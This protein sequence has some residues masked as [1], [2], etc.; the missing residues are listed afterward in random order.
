MSDDEGALF[1]LDEARTGRMGRVEAALRRSLSAGLE[2]GTI[3]DVDAALA[4]SALVLA[5]ALDAADAVGGL[6]GGYLAAQTQPPLQKAL[7]ALRL[8]AELVAVAAP[9]PAPDSQQDLTNF[10]NDLG[11]ALGPA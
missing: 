2:D 8:P 6:K 5:R 7:H 9:L 1:G 10:L 3:R 11:D 4:Q